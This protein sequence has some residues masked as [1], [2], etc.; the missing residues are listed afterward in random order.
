MK[1]SCNKLKT[2]IKNS[3]NIDWIKIWDKFALR[4]A[5]V[6]EIV[7]KGKDL[8]DVV[9]VEITKCEKHPTKDKYSVLE[10]FDG[11]KTYSILCGAPNVRLGLKAF[12]VKVGG[13]V[14]GFKIEAKKIA[15]VLS[16]GML[17]AG[18]ELGISS[19][20]D[21]IIE[22]PEDTKLGLD[23]KDVLPINDIIIEI[24][25]KSLTNRPDL[26][27]HYGIAREIAAITSSELL[28]LELEKFSND[29]KDLDVNI[30]SNYVHRYTAVKMDNIK[31]NKTPLEM[32]M[33]LYYTG[34]RTISLLVDL[35]NYVMSEVGLPMHAF[36]SRE[37]KSIN[38]E[39]AKKDE[40]FTT[41]DNV[42][43]KLNEEVLLIK[44]EKEAIGLAGI[45][46]GLNSEV[47][48]DT[49]SIVLEAAVFD[50]VNIRKSATYLGHRTEASARYEKSLDPELCEIAAARFAYLLKEINPEV[51]VA[52]NFTDVYNKKYETV[53]VHL[54]KEKLYKY[55]GITVSDDVV[56]NILNSLEFKVEINEKEFIVTAPSFRATKDISMDADIIEEISRMYGY[57]NI[58]EKPIK[59]DITFE[60]HETNFEIEYELKNYLTKKYSASEVHSYLWY[61]SEFLKKCNIEKN[62]ITVINKVKNNILRDELGLSLLPF[63][64]LNYK[65]Y[66][67]FIIYE[68]GT[69]VK[70]DENKLALSI[71][72]C[73]HENDAKI[74]YMN[75]KKMI[76]EI[77]RVFKNKEVVFKDYSVDKYYNSEY[78]KKI[79]IDNELY[80]TIN[81]VSPE[82][83][84]NLGKKK[85]VTII[86]IDF[87][88]FLMLEKDV[89]TIKEQTKFQAVTLDYAVL[90]PK[91]KNYEYLNNI[92]VNYHNEFV[93]SFKLIETYEEEN[94]IKYLIRFN[95][96]S[97]NKTIDGEDLLEIKETF[98]KYLKDHDLDIIE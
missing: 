65:N 58:E 79:F 8:K 92:I 90:V 75:S 80:G 50:A 91:D 51:S 2:Y 73:G 98:I 33:F 24:D 53:T 20:H 42:N 44:N 93:N 57:E 94:V 49:T 37:V 89:K 13:E 88:K 54:A 84:F 16:E 27:S 34:Y 81:I 96:S 41:L 97:L 30:N 82:V 15:G 12:L 39:L 78:A 22:L 40:E 9:T 3:D 38:V 47:L 62:N 31:T 29:K 52:S 36:D 25:N 83:S 5:E 67:D 7:E 23:I 72:N 48:D 21:G 10:V 11:E 64:E 63:V 56:K 70:D 45:M 18:D 66:N 68:I 43:R 71:L 55:M 14:A 69:I 46:G 77:F 61:D 60:V 35:T 59:A 26:W 76:N 74:I 6:E 86:D 17:C 32:Q 19:D 87:T 28:P 4:T 85:F 1:I 95:V